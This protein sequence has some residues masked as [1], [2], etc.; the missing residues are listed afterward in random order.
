MISVNFTLVIQVINFIVLLLVLNAILYKP[1][2]AKIRE[3][4]NRIKEGREKAAELERQV[5]DHE[6]R[7]AAELGKAKQTAAQ[8]KA[9]LLAEAK[10]KEA[11]VLDKAR[12]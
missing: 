1:V 11:D 9:A 3:R 10:K 2:L 4:E 12:A 6:A 5:Q 8:E 7:H